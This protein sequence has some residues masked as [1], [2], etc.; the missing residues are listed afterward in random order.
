[1]DEDEDEAGDEEVTFPSVTFGT[2]RPPFLAGLV[3]M[4]G[5]ADAV[6]FSR[7]PLDT[8]YSALC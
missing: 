8:S 3:R 4:L 1:M 7:S 2:P 5:R 6:T